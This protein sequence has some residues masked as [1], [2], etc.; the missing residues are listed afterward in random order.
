MNKQNRKALELAIEELQKARDII[1]AQKEIIE[2]MRDEEQ[3]KFDNMSEGLQQ[4]EKGMS[5]E[6]AADCLDDGL[7]EVETAEKSCDNCIDYL[8]SAMDA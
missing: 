1:A 3:E 8:Q 6:A 5:I 2:Q 4:S 7:N